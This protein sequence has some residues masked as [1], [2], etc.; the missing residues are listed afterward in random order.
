MNH[1]K[2]VKKIINNENLKTLEPDFINLEN[3]VNDEICKQLLL[4]FEETL[5]K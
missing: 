4:N 2:I 1:L 5:K 3:K